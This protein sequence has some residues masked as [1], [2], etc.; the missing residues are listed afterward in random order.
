MD[1]IEYKHLIFIRIPYT[2]SRT[3]INLSEYFQTYRQLLF[4]PGSL[5]LKDVTNGLKL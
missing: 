1:C 5:K 4:C 2:I 3:N